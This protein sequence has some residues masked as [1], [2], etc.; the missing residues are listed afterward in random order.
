VESIKQDYSHSV[1]NHITLSLVSLIGIGLITIF[2]SFWVTELAD[3]DAQA[4]N[5]SGSMRMQ[6]YHVGLAL[7]D[8]KNDQAL[9]YI[10][11]LDNTWNHSLFALQ[12]EGNSSQAL[13]SAFHQ[14]HSHWRETLRPLLLDLAHTPNVIPFPIALIDKQV[15][16]T[17]ELVN[18]FQQAA[19]SK[20]RD[21]RFVQLFAL[22]IVMGVGSLVVYLIRDRVEKPLLQ[23]TQA[24]HRIGKGD[25]G[26]QVDIDGRDELGLLGATI[27]R[28]STS[29]SQM[30]DEMESQVKQ[31]TLEL[32]R[33]N[34]ILE[35]LF[36]TARKILYSH[37]QPLNYQG[38]LD[39]LSQLAGSDSDLE[40]ELCLF[41]VKGDR[42]Y[43]QVTPR[44]YTPSD[45]SKRSCEQCHGEAPFCL[46]DKYRLNEKF[47]ITREE[48][49]Y[50]VI[51]VRGKDMLSLAPWQEQL[52]RSVADQLALAL[53]LS[54]QQEQQHRLAMLNER[55][56]IARELHDSLAQ[57]LSYLKIQVTRL[58]KSNDKERY[59]LQQ[60]IIDELREGLS[61][62][63]RHLRELLTTFRLKIDTGGLNE[64]LQCT[65][66]TL[67]ERS[68]MQVDL[69]YQLAN[70]PLSPT[71]EIHLLQIVRE[72]SQN[73]VNHSNGRQVDITLHQLRDESIELIVDDDGIGIS[74]SPEKLNHYGLA[75]INERARHLGGDVNIVARSNGGTR[76]LLH[77]KPSFL[78]A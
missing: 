17:D 55:S 7:K 9:A 54:A 16:L 43:L 4:I 34:T 65:V 21:L 77:F 50:G 2:I 76:V 14:A 28:M 30:Y 6:T 29:I 20:I 73:A 8:N 33:N 57:S 31:R 75:I 60:P 35:F 48:T 51:N 46:L 1:M 49:H 23:L 64:A 62:A 27:N 41:T 45:C 63:Y 69:H 12:R 5:L 70:I 78:A 68:D 59:D 66:A 13:N 44:H 22:F 37:N 67:N 36:S 47:P 58:Q 42:P 39:E 38:L 53:S 40:L 52:F 3:Q 24:A 11:K 19:E 25:F 26:H 32:R 15:D 18:R 71:E 56:V 74:D 61:A 10:E 72:A